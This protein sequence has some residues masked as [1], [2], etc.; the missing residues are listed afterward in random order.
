MHTM[1]HYQKVHFQVSGNTEPRM[2]NP[3]LKRLRKAL[4]NF[5]FE[6]DSISARVEDVDDLVVNP[7]NPSFLEGRYENVRFEIIDRDDFGWE[8]R[9]NNFIK[10]KLASLVSKLEFG[11]YRTVLEVT[12]IDYI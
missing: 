7:V 10:N 11:R 12:R 1:T 9:W 8:N 5:R 6:E 2:V 4:E 3:L